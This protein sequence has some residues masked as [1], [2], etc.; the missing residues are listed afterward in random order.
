MHHLRPRTVLI[1]G[2]IAI[3]LP[4]LL[5]VG[6]YGLITGPSRHTVPIAQATTGSLVPASNPTASGS[7]AIPVEPVSSLPHTHDPVAYARA[8]AAALFDWDT[9]AGYLPT[10]ITAPVLADADPSGE[11]TA[12]LITDTTTYEPTTDQWLDLGA[13]DVTQHLDITSAAIPAD[14]STIVSTAH[15]QLRPGTLAITI[16]GIRHRT[17][18]WQGAPASTSDPV[19]F[20]IFEACQPSWPRCHLL[21]LSQLNNPLS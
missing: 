13:M 1:L 9:N 8:V 20:T 12:G 19:S 2:T 15:G 11:E 21:R 4:I 5:G 18:T 16:R 14:W 17:G 10:D 6:I 3:A 7:P